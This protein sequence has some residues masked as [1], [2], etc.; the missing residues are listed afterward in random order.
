[1]GTYLFPRLGCRRFLGFSGVAAGA[2]S[3]SKFL[4]FAALVVFA[5]FL[6]LGIMAG[7]A[8]F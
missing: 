7:E 8:L 2:A 4:F 3:I 6:I 5:I 1:M